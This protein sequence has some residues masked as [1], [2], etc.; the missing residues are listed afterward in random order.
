MTYANFYSAASRHA[1]WVSV[2]RTVVVANVANASTP[3]YK[4]KDVEAFSLEAASASPGL[5]V[6]HPAHFAAGG[7]SHHL[8]S[9]D[10]ATAAEQ[11]HSGNTVSLDREMM[12]AASV[13]RGQGL[14]AGLMKAFNKLIAMSTRG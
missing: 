2:R 13:S 6:S 3:G 11:H 5:G 4:A 1:E 10:L 14:N 12:K 9:A 7:P 8:V